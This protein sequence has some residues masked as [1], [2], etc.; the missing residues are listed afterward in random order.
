LRKIQGGVFQAAWS[1]FAMEVVLGNFWMDASTY[2][3]SLWFR[4]KVDRGPL[5]GA[6]HCSGLGSRLTI[7]DGKQHG[8]GFR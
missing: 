7:T 1:V 3:L 6:T 2:Y 5:M 4:F 8:E